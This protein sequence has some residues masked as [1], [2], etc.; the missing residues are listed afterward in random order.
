MS[1]PLPPSLSS[2]SSPPQSDPNRYRSHA[3]ATLRSSSL[4]PL[5]NA[6]ARGLF[7]C[8]ATSRA[9]SKNFRMRL[10]A[11][12]IRRP[13]HWIHALTSSSSSDWHPRHWIRLR[14]KPTCPDELA[15]QKFGAAAKPTC[16]LRKLS[17]P[18]VALQEQL[19][20]QTM[21]PWKRMKRTWETCL[22]FKVGCKRCWLP[23]QEL[24]Q[25]QR[26]WQQQRSE[27]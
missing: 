19:Q 25:Q 9:S 27:Q 8:L 7:N 1:C 23:S 6:S 10:H 15:L 13:R 26:W 11:S 24:W 18:Q 3:I 22:R 4:S 2:S 16:S 12:W 17:K 5:S 21:D 14:I 20:E